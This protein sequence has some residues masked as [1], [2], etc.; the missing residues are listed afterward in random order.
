V[1]V[2]HAL[3]TC[4]G[5]SRLDPDDFVSE[6]TIL[7]VCAGLVSYDNQTEIIRLVH[8]TA[9]E[10]FRENWLKW[11]KDESLEITSTCITYMSFSDFESGPCKTQKETDKRFRDFVLLD[12]AAK[13]WGDHARELETTGKGNEQEPGDDKYESHIEI[14]TSFLLNEQLISTAVQ[15]MLS[16]QWG[17]RNLDTL[18]TRPLHLTTYFGIGRLSALLLVSDADVNTPSWFFDENFYGVNEGVTP[19]YI[20][21]Y[22]GYGKIAKLLLEK[23]AN[24]NAPNWQLGTALHGACE[25]ED[26]HVAKLILDTH[27]VKIDSKDDY[28]RTPL[29]L[30][31]ERGNEAVVKL[32]VDPG[33][34]EVD[35]RDEDGRTPLL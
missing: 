17:E 6:Q 14:V 24:V 8:Y 3:A 28:G 33:K 9:Q 5:K 25:R 12:Y 1:E 23:R 32:L 18:H 29:S 26:S 22:K 16:G 19:L 20:A 11:F 4:I 27:D 34:V 21:C 13:H 35:S 7:S 31:A 30:A 10:Y 15:A 2:K